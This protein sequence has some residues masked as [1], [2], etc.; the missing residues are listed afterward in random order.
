MNSTT[1]RSYRLQHLYFDLNRFNSS[2]QGLC[3]G[4]KTR[5]EEK[6]QEKGDENEEVVRV[7][8]AL[9]ITLL[10]ARVWVLDNIYVFLLFKCAIVWLCDMT[11]F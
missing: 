3:S 8:K 2:Q 6:Q 7:V 4:S 9:I 10:H 5:N 11:I 1:Q